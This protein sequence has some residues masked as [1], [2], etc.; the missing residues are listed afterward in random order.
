MTG[1]A[2]PSTV[3]LLGL[4]LL[5]PALAGCLG[6]GPSEPSTDGRA[7]PAAPTT[8]PPGNA[9][10]DPDRTETGNGTGS[11]NAGSEEIPELSGARALQDLETFTRAAPVRHSDLPTHDAAVEWLEASFRDAGLETIVHEAEVEPGPNPIRPCPVRDHVPDR[12]RVRNVLA[13]E[14]GAT[15]PNRT[16]V[17]AAHYDGAVGGVGHAYDPGS[18]TVMLLELARAASQ[19]EFHHTIILAAWDGQECDFLLGSTTW[20]ED[21][22]PD[23]VTIAAD[24]TLD[25]VG[26]NWPVEG[27]QI[28]A[29]KG[30]IGNDDNE[31][32]RATYRNAT[33]EELGYPEGPVSYQGS[34]DRCNS[35]LAFAQA[36]I[37]YLFFSTYPFGSQ[38]SGGVPHYPFWNRLDTV[39]Q[40]IA[41]AGGRDELVD[42]FE[43]VLEVNL[44]GLVRLDRALADGP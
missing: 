38:F 36:G 17:V 22:E 30:W 24:V 23:N 9:T 13:V 33:Y 20:F 35:H 16:I 2:D 32:L 6:A 26:L 12:D 8:T 11:A 19:L 34:C 7:G 31:T 40:M 41:W 3:V 29:L 44:H 21:P 39:E 43:T 37:P 42:G 10:E 4:V 18:A 28:K 27:P 1:R 15:F 25:M 5:A 14:R